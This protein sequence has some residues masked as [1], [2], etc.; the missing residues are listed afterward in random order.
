M[1]EDERCDRC[2]YRK[3]E[4]VE[5]AVLD[6]VRARVQAA[7]AR[8]SACEPLIDFVLDG[9]PREREWEQTFKE[10]AQAARNVHAGSVPDIRSEPLPEAETQIVWRCEVCGAVDEPQ[11]CLGICIWR[12]FDWVDA[13]SYRAALAELADAERRARAA[14]DLVALM[15]FTR[16]RADSW[17]ANWRALQTRG[18]AVRGQ[19]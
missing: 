6:E 1:R 18:R 4:L 11:E 16:P 14:S 8:R 15:A 3:L 10:L 9:E 19:R 17:E 13:D 7:E 5:A 12:R 2:S